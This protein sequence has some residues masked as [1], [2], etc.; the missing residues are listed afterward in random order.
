MIEEAQTDTG[1]PARPKAM[2][3]RR[4][5]IYRCKQECMHGSLDHQEPYQSQKG[6]HAGQE[7]TIIVI[8][9]TAVPYTT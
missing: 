2:Q 9:V 6:M 5:S 3:H 4:R 1:M 8:M 7:G